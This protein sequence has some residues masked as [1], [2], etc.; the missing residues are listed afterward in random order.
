MT[1]Q[2]DATPYFPLAIFLWHASL[3]SFSFSAKTP[4]VQFDSRSL[5]RIGGRLAIRAAKFGPKAD[6]TIWRV[7][8][9]YNNG[10][11]DVE[12]KNEGTLRDNK[13]F[14]VFPIVPFQ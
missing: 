8:G 4:T 9:I 1:A 7:G 6:H 3:V 13:N 14:F 12:A 10:V 11:L 5:E 2:F